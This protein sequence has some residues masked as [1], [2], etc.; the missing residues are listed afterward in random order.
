MKDR[1]VVKHNINPS[2]LDH[3]YDTEIRISGPH[4]TYH[5][6]FWVFNDLKLNFF[7]QNKIKTSVLKS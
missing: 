2:I 3:Q 6:W 7:L 4:I 1:M 5:F